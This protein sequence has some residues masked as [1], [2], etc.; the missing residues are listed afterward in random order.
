M[1][2]LGMLIV[3]FVVCGSATGCGGGGGASLE[4]PAFTNLAG[5]RWNV[6]DTVSAYNSCNAGLGLSDAWELDVLAQSGN[7]ISFYDTR[8]G[9]TG[10]VNGTLS[11]YTLSYSGSRFAIQGCSDMTATY[12]VTLNNAGTSFSG[13]ATIVC[14]DAVPA[15]SV[16]VTVTGARI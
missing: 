9:I 7:T 14:H 15:C 4:P 5:S 8:A 3:V 10:A 16:P 13:T 2:I 12:T 1:R 11:G 6:T